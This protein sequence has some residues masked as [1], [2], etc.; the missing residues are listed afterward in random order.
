M[1]Q[2]GPLMESHVNTTKVAAG[3]CFFSAGSRPESA[4]ELIQIVG[5]IQFLAVVGLMSPFLW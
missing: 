3:L 2:L 1:I 5:Q 4:S